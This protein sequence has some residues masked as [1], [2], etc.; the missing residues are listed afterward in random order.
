MLDLLLKQ[1]LEVAGVFWKFKARV[2]NESACLIQTIRSDNGKKYTFETFNRFCEEVGIEHQLTAPYTPQ[3]NDVNERRNRFVMEMT[4][5]MLHEKNLP[6]R[7]WG[8]VATTVVCLQNRISTK[9]V[10]NLASFEV[11]YGYKSSLKFLRVF[12]CLCFTYIPQVKCDKLDKKAKASIFVGYNTISKTY[13][14]F[15]PHT[16]RVIASR[17]VH[18][19]E[20]EQWNWE[21]LTK[22]NQISNAPNNFIFGS[23]LEESEDERQEESEDE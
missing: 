22:V 15:Q 19:A 14:V 2:E 16:S 4:R 3:Q 23:M 20:N 9:A 5:C 17:D 8:K 10:K 18:F 1:K 13:R 12:W 7:S 21:E 6:K 11:W